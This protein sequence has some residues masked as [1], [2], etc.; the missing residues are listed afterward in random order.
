MSC[1][2]PRIFPF[3]VE[4]LAVAESFFL[5]SFFVS[6]FSYT[7]SVIAFVIQ[8]KIYKAIREIW[9]DVVGNAVIP[10]EDFRRK[11]KEQ[12]LKYLN[13]EDL[14]KATRLNED[15]KR[16]LLLAWR[17]Y[18]HRFWGLGALVSQSIQ[19]LEIDC[20]GAGG[21]VTDDGAMTTKKR[22]MTALSG[23]YQGSKSSKEPSF[24]ALE[25]LHSFQ[26]SE[27]EAYFD[28]IETAFIMTP[29][30]FFRLRLLAICSS[31]NSLLG[32]YLATTQM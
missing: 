31:E 2:I 16:K 15:Q 9:P 10:A 23:F 14:V 18:Q 3:V 5:Y 4:T 8:V 11:V 29:L 22:D 30:Q 20:G 6:V 17:E 32:M 26:K 12:C 24:Q 19:L 21:N 13:H 1:P 27:R 25:S 28:M 7:A